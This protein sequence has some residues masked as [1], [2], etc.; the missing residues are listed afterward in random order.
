VWETCPKNFLHGSD[1]AG[2]RTANRVSTIRKSDALPVN[3]RATPDADVCRRFTVSC[4]WPMFVGNSTPQAVFPYHTFFLETIFFINMLSS[5]DN[6][7]QILSVYVFCKRTLTS[8]QRNGKSWT[9]DLMFDLVFKDKTKQ[10]KI[11]PVWDCGR[12]LG[13]LRPFQVRSHVSS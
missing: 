10:I 12:L 6:I 2:N 13:N 8:H 5:F 11:S 3:P 9:T 1:L 4:E 7:L